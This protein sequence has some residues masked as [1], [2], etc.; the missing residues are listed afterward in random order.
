MELFT[1]VSFRRLLVLLVLYVLE[2]GGGLSVCGGWVGACVEALVFRF[3]K[4]NIPFE[5]S[6]NSVFRP[7]FERNPFQKIKN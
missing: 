7:F 4:S 3:K 6:A 5:V 2:G 1:R